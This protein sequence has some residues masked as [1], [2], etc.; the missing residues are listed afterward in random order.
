MKKR[1]ALI[2]VLAFAAVV[3]LSGVAL[4]QTTTGSQPG[5]PALFQ[6]FLGKLATNLGIDQSKLENAI[7][8]TQLQMVDEAVQQG[9]MTS[10]Q[11]QK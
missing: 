1:I 3:I 10:S 2:V 4:A 9:K 7:K 6:N 11:A 8:Q 5:M